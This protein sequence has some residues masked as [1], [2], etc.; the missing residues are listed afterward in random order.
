MRPVVPG[1]GR[2]ALP[3]TVCNAPFSAA[4]LDPRGFVRACCMN[5]DHLL[6][7]LRTERLADIWHG[8]TT[9]SLRHRAGGRR[10]VPGVPAVRIGPRGALAR[11]T[12]TPDLRPLPARRSRPRPPR[13][14]HLALGNHCNLRCGIYNGGLSSSIRR[15]QGFA[16]LPNPYG[17]PVLRGPRRVPPHLEELQFLGRRTVPGP[18]APPC[19]G[20]PASPRPV[21]EVP[22]DH[23]RHHLE[24]QSRTDPGG[25]PRAGHRVAGRGDRRDVR[26]DP[27]RRQA[28]SG[29]R[30]RDHFKAYCDERGASVAFAF[31]L[32]TVNWHEFGSLPLRRGSGSRRV[33]EPRDHPRRF[34]LAWCTDAERADII[35]RME[36][37]DGDVADLPRNGAVWRAELDHLRRHRRP[38]PRADR[39]RTSAARWPKPF[40]WACTGSGARQLRRGRGTS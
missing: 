25:F 21:N 32:M 37:A 30:D 38:S 34:S 8:D 23:Q 36:Q 39:V 10:P 26:V 1:I 33:R 40:P 18:G 16:P 24:R 28:G 7:D 27:R 29:H 5:N 2:P 11:P 13:T 6:G 14:L 15:D 35:A 20:P 12:P 22:R 31:S 4:Y 9:R 17:G 19:V 3:A